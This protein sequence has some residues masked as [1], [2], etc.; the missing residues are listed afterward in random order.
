[1][2]HSF[3]MWI[4]LIS[5]TVGA[6][7]C[8]SENTAQGPLAPDPNFTPRSFDVTPTPLPTQ[9]T[10]QAGGTAHT[11]APSVDAC[12][13]GAVTYCVLNPA[14]TQAT[15]GQTICVSGW[16]GTVRPPSSYTDN[17]KRSQLSSLANLHTGDSEWTTSGT[18]E[19]H[20]LPLELGG[21]PSDT[22]NLSPEQHRFSHAKDADENRFKQMVCSGTPLA[23][24]QADFVNKWLQ[25]WPGYK[26]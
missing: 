5:L 13:S 1:V 18:E 3:K 6:I 14:V 24:A 17:L 15:I 10:Q 22:L 4:C 21:S 12:H 11:S 7:S 23:T 16:T 9:P 19:D 20:R 8:T 25:G 2:N 26:E